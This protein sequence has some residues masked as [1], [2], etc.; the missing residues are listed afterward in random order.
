VWRVARAVDPAILRQ[1]SEADVGS[2]VV[3][4]FR[5]TG[6]GTARVVLALTHGDSSPKAVRAAYYVVKVR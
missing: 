5:A 3:L 2:S 4:V 1:V 6:V